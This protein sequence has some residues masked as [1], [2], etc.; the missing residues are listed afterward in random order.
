MSITVGL[1]KEAC[2]RGWSLHQCVGDNQQAPGSWV[3]VKPPVELVN[4]KAVFSANYVPITVDAR[5]PGEQGLVDGQP[6]SSGKYADIGGMLF[7]ADKRIPEPM[8]L[9]RLR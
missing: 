1:S 9:S 4:K 6:V 3:V 5:G 8:V 2:E 7:Q